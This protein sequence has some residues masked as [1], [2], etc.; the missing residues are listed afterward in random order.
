M[1]ISQ[2]QLLK[3]AYTELSLSAIKHTFFGCK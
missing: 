2:V 1:K 3:E